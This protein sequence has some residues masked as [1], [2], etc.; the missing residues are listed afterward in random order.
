MWQSQH[1]A[2][3]GKYI[4]NSAMSQKKANEN[5]ESPYWYVP[6]DP[7]GHYAAEQIADMVENGEGYIVDHV[8]SRSVRFHDPGNIVSLKEPRTQ[9]RKPPA[10][11]AA[12]NY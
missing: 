8:R 9:A 10:K 4:W 7:F 3:S 11:H 12:A 2:Q 5:G 6:G 1:H